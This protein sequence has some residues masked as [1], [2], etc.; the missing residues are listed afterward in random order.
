MKTRLLLAFLMLPFAA[1]AHAVTEL[2]LWHALEGPR[3][4]DLS[5]LL[6]VFNA[7]QKDYQVVAT[8]KGSYDEVLA[9]GRAARSAAP[10]ILQLGDAST[11]GAMTD[12]RLFKPFYQLM[13]ET[14]EPL[15]AKALIPAVARFYSDA[16]GN[17]LALPFNIA[18]PVFYYNKDAL[19]KAGIDPA[20]P[21]K[22]WYDVQEAGIKLYQAQ[23]TPCALTTTY[24]S[25][26][27][28]ENLLAWHN[29]E[30][31]TRANGFDGAGAKLS[32][33]GFL[34]MRHM[35]LLS[36]WI[37]AQIFTYSGRR[38]EGE[39]KF[40]AGECAMLTSSSAAYADIRRAAAFPFGVMPM[41]YYDDFKGAPFHTTLGGGSLWTTAG[42]SPAEYR[43][44]AKFFVFLTRPEIQAHWHQKTGYLPVTYAAYELSRKQGFYEQNPGADIGVLQLASKGPLTPYAHGVRLGNYELIRTAI[45]DEIEQVWEGK[46]PPKAGLDQAVKRGNEV[47][48][49]Y[50]RAPQQ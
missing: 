14:G 43:G 3:A 10:H 11:L 33:N 28:L 1:P 20:K 24:P 21:L 34:A 27:M 4:E 29:E 42:K 46:T 40:I 6:E 25:W 45:D 5:R 38:D 23:A 8:F 41:P 18:T 39:K 37:R 48:Q 36:S 19:Q 44:V 13:A 50:D 30:F 26:V 7:G 16:K 32:F 9:A 22:T 47:L 2:H 17:L 15:T 31:A 49:R 12:K 35:S